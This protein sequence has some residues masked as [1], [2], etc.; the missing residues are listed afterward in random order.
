[1]KERRLR[2]RIKERRQEQREQ[3]ERL[4]GFKENKGEKH[5]KENSIN[6]KRQKK[7]KSRSQTVDY[8]TTDNKLNE[9]ISQL[10][11]RFSE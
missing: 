2:G 11:L 1:M 7:K 3:E 8:L 9:L 10:K 4:Y 6:L 5:S